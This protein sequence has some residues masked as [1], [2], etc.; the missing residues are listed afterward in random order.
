MGSVWIWRGSTGGPIW[1]ESS[2]PRSPTGSLEWEDPLPLSS[3]VSIN[4]YGGPHGRVGRPKSALSLC[5][6]S[7]S[8]CFSHLSFPLF[9]CLC[10]SV[11]LPSLPVSVLL[12]LS[13]SGSLPT[14]TPLS[15]PPW[16]SLLVSK[17]Q[18][19]H[20]PG[21]SF[22]FLC[23]SRPL[24]AGHGS[25]RVSPGGLKGSEG[26]SGGIIQAD[27]PT[28]SWDSLLLLEIPHAL[29]TPWKWQPFLQS[30][31]SCGPGPPYQGPTL[32]EWE[33]IVA[34]RTCSPCRQAGKEPGCMCADYQFVIAEFGAQLESLFGGPIFEG[35]ELPP[36]GLAW[37]GEECSFSKGKT[38]PHTGF[39]SRAPAPA[40]MTHRD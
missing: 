25:L 5:P 2:L 6:L 10:R 4:R 14:C 21:L 29:K 19:L 9:L 36:S 12:P 28:F 17:V 37:G 13:V 3:V 31:A 33:G 40:K 27:H 24:C 16:L 22:L 32:G 34:C 20:C 35:P 18:A 26:D 39:P 11:C 23:M 7:L 15:L 30:Q 1:G 8:H 38:L